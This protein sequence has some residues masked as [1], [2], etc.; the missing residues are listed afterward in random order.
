[1]TANSETQLLSGAVQVT[2]GFPLAFK[3]WPAFCKATLAQSQDVRP[4]R[5]QT[6]SASTGGFLQEAFLDAL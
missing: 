2:D 1:M 3:R 5:A 4:S 6:G